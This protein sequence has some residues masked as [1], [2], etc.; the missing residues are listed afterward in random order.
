MTVKWG[1]LSINWLIITFKWSTI[2]DNQMTG[3]NFQ[4]S[5]DLR[6]WSSDVLINFWQLGIKRHVKWAWSSVK[7]FSK[8]VEWLF[9][10]LPS[11]VEPLIFKWFVA[12]HKW[13]VTIDKW[14]VMIQK[15]QNLP[16]Y[17]KKKH[18]PSIQNNLHNISNNFRDTSRTSTHNH[19]TQGFAKSSSLRSHQ[20]E[21]QA[22][23]K[24]PLIP[25]L[26]LLIT[27][28][29]STNEKTGSKSPTCES[30]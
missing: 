22:Q 7:K 23:W 14:F 18:H 5:S 24:Y 13:F 20:R 29:A 16:K 21:I 10:W 11:I 8:C 12:I 3:D 27:I 25:T 30:Q 15:I 4:L 9:K 28:T 17:S 26:P 19:I 2:S 6:K 1:M